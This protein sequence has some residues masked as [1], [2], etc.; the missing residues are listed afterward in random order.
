M[1]WLKWLET[2]K[3]CFRVCFRMEMDE[4]DEKN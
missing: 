4:K 3:T 2:S 1:N